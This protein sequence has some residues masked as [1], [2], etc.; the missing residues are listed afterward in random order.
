[1]KFTIQHILLLTCSLFFLPLKGQQCN[2]ANR[3]GGAGGEA[4]TH[5]VNIQ[6]GL[7]VGGIFQQQINLAANQL[8]SQGGFDIFLCWYDSTQQEINSLSIGN[9]S[10]NILKSIAS[11]STGNI[12]LSGT[13]SGVLNL[14]AFQ[15]QSN[16][17]SHFICKINSQAQVLWA[18]LLLGKGANNVLDMQISPD[19]RFLWLSGDFND[20]L[21]YQNES[22]YSLSTYNLFVAKL[23]TGNAQIQ[24]L[25]KTPKSRWAKANSVAPLEDGSAWVA[26]EFIDSLYMPDT[27]YYFSFLHTDILF[28]QIDSSG[29][30][31]KSKRW[32]GVYDSNPKKLRLSPDRQTLW[33]TGDFVAVLNIDSFQLVTAR[34]FYDAFWI[35]INLDGVPLA[36]GQSNTKANCYIFDLTFLNDQVFIGGYF[37]DSLLG[38][39]QMHY[40]NGGF[41]AF[42]F[43]IDSLSSL[44]ENSVTFGGTANDQIN[45]MATFNN[46]VHACGTFQQNMFIDNQLLT[47][48]GFSDGWISCLNGFDN[49]ST[50]LLDELDISIYI[51]PNP[52]ENLFY[53][54]SK[55]CSVQKW[56]LYSAHGEKILEGTDLNIDLTAFPTG[57]YLL[58]IHTD[59]GFITKKLIKL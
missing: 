58:K 52:S 49:T 14:G 54:E 40:T 47:A 9:S 33:M 25:Q 42:Y 31:I 18:E 2:W 57:F 16:T 7:V 15:L 39:T 38:A 50:E 32:G 55:N 13:F 22:L 45:G 5:L 46:R 3:I 30:W 51:F 23:H 6:N 19:N 34:R 48:Q 36:V 26:A 27:V 35:K 56:D 41:D 53:I 20:S 43:E 11:D 4:A 59:Q 21:F 28:A 24:W 29:N 37:Q 10:N 44:L 17:V 1:M 12:Y 8:N